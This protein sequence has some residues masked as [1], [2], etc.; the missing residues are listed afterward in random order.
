MNLVNAEEVFDNGVLVL[1]DDSFDEAIAKYDY[2]LVEFYAPWCGH[3][4][5]L[6]PEYEAAA[7]VLAAQ[8][9]PRTI[10]KV[11]ATENKA[12][13]ERMAI[14]GF[15]TLY[16][17][18]QGTKMDYTGGR[19]KD[20]I[21]EWINKKTGPASTEVDCEGMKAKTAEAKLALS[22]F[23]ALEGDLFETFMKGAKNPAI[24]EKFAF[25]HT[26]DTSCAGDYGVT[27]SGISL[28]RNF[29]ESP[30]A[31]SGTSEDDIVE[32][33]K[34]S[35]V[36]RL[37]TFSEDYIEPIFGDHQSAIIL[38]TE[39]SD[40]AYQGVFAQAAKDLQGEILFVTSGVSEGIQSRLG[41]F[42][43]VEKADLPQLRII[44]PEEQM[45]KYNYD[46]DISGLTGESIG[47]F[48]ADFKA[49][50]LQPH[51][52]SEPVPDPATTDGVTVLVGKTFD[53]IVKDASK[54]V[55]VKYYAPWCGHCKSLAPIWEELGK[56]TADIEDLVIAKFDATANEVAGLDIRGYPT[57]KFYPKDN[58][59][60]VDYS[61]DRQL[62]DFKSFLSENSSAYK[63]AR[64][65]EEQQAEL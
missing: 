48:V 41:E 21:I 51:L 28:S 7:E 34:K 54:D 15:P 33:A 32:F 31:V 37:I 58:K 42:I 9:P 36:P 38:F 43:G 22:Y 50:S 16:F 52:K 46:G 2:L 17:W 25:L 59:D 24:S 49:G 18:N 13:A 10:A 57:L 14:K 55:L 19:T 27:G 4:K 6:T 3:C 35:S 26:S 44:S 39:E 62:P 63:A 65:T 61:G 60:G 53:E 20:T 12:L 5:K 30:I 23:G 29:D 1:G 40:S 45:L 11:D 47:K 56:D 64:A 8:D